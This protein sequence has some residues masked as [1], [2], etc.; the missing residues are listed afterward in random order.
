MVGWSPGI[1]LWCLDYYLSCFRE[2]WKGE[3]LLAMSPQQVE[4]LNAETLAVVMIVFWL[5]SISLGAGPITITP[6]CL[7]FLTLSHQ[8]VHKMHVCMKKNNWDI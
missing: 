4:C 5:L 6:F 3:K 2:L 8:T 1:L 7:L